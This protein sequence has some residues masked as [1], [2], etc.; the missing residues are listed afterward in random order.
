[1]IA[2]RETEDIALQTNA[3]ILARP[4]GNDVYGIDAMQS[5]DDIID[6]TRATTHVVEDTVAIGSEFLKAVS[7]GD[8]GVADEFRTTPG[9]P[10]SDESAGRIQGNDAKN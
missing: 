2:R 8:R 3:I 4:S 5:D 10:D 1:M 9:Q 7:G 6:D